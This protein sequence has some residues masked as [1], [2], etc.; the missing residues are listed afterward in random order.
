MFL[1]LIQCCS[2]PVIVVC[3][4]L[5]SLQTL[6]AYSQFGIISLQHEVLTDESGPVREPTLP[7]SSLKSVNLDLDLSR[8]VASPLTDQ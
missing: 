8:A 7:C 4:S 3:K 1:S 2:D 5:G 6:T